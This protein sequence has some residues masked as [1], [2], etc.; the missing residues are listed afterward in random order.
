MLILSRGHL[1]WHFRRKHRRQ[2][3]QTPDRGQKGIIEC[4][5]R[6]A[7]Q[8]L[9]KRKRGIQGTVCPAESM[10]LVRLSVRGLF[11]DLIALFLSG[12]SD[13]AT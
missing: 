9:L 3:L 1:F 2:W 10:R 11:Q 12:V 8:L 5:Y 13:K 4:V 6:S 7:G